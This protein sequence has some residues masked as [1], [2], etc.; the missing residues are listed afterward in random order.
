MITGPAAVA[1][2]SFE[3]SLPGR[4]LHDTGSEPGS[5]ALIAFALAERLLTRSSQNWS[6]SPGARYSNA[7]TPVYAMLKRLQPTLSKVEQDFIRPEAERLV[8]KLQLKL[9]HQQRES[10]GLRLAEIDDLRP[11]VG[12][13]NGLPDFVWLPVPGGKI[14]LESNAG[15]FPVA[16]AFSDLA[17]GMSSNTL[18]SCWR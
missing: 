15:T 11:G 5:L 13:K 2:L 6:K 3:D 18:M 12:L 9:T 1:G 17:I 8:E 14:T 16:L 4:V 7:E 10:I